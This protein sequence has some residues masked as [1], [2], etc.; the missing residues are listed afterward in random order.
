MK[1]RRF[2]EDQA[3]SVEMALTSSSIGLATIAIRRLSSNS[4]DNHL[5]GIFDDNTTYQRGQKTVQ[6]F[7]SLNFA[8]PGW[9]FDVEGSA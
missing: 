6:R 7:E 8:F 9:V 3:L 4:K 2:A 1:S 5:K